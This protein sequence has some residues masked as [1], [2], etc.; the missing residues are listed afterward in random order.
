MKLVF[1]HGRSQG[2][3]DPVELLAEWEASFDAG[4]HAAGLARPSDLEVALPFYGDTLDDLV[5]QLESPLIGDVAERGVA[6]ADSAE[7]A[8]FRG[9]ILREM[10][11]E[12][13]ISQGEIEAAYEGEAT[14][15]RGVQNWGWV[16]AL[17]KVL[18]RS[19]RF[20]EFALDRFTRDVFLYLTNRTVRK[21]IDAIVQPHVDEQPCVVVGH[22]LGSVV[23]YSVLRKTS[24][25]VVR[26]V[27]LG[28]PLGIDAV[29]SRLELVEMPPTTEAWHNA[30]DRDDVVALYPLSRDRFLV[31]P[32]I[33]NYDG[34]DNS[35]DN[36]HGIVGYLP[37]RWVA[38][39]IHAAL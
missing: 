12:L 28:S 1:I 9:E 4:L 27:T 15:P 14:Q 22:S 37:D 8:R 16:H 26:Y 38:K 18:D 31:D 17:L 29:R 25:R 11:D 30:R 3:R 21:R 36:E 6:D 13:G 23:G 35:T 20:G 7:E 19:S 5:E 33:V 34:V 2:G 24:Q 10:A 32:P 39:A